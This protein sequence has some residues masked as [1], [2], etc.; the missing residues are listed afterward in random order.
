MKHES[1]V[2]L[3]ANAT[4]ESYLALRIQHP[5]TYYYFGLITTGEGSAPIVSAW[6]YE[7]LE[8]KA[9]AYP[10]EV[11]LKSEL[12]WSYAD[13]P[14][15]CFG[16]VYFGAVKRA[17]EQRPRFSVHMSESEWLNELNARLDAMESAMLLLNNE[18]LFGI[19]EERESMVVLVEVMPPDASNTDRAK[20]LNPPRALSRWL[21]EAA[22]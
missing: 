11:G 4:R 8:V 2:T 22:E 19:G 3:I 20:R 12:K 10:E 5:G 13:S 9:A 18:G 7:A 14:Y 21:V 6:T 16:E 15:C 17:F 1:L